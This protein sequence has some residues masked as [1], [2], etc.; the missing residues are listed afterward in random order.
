MKNVRYVVIVNFFLSC[1]VSLVKFSSW[2]KFHINNITGSGVMTITFYKGLTRNPE[3]RNTPVW[4]LLNIWRLWQERDTKFGK[5]VCYKILMNAAKC[6]C[7]NFTVSVLLR[8]NQLG[9]GAEFN[10]LSPLHP[11]TQIRV[12]NKNVWAYCKLHLTNYIKILRAA[13][14]EFINYQ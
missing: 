3:I 14:S 7:L 12:K 10:P 5:N 4:V 11:H 13:V 8:E 9:G 6:Q 2:F 1:F